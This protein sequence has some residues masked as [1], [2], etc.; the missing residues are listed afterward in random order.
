M[1]TSGDDMNHVLEKV[2]A[3]HKLKREL[4]ELTHRDIFTVCVAEF[5]L[6]NPGL[7]PLILHQK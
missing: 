1:A 2:Y 7:S 5:G 4:E 6:M 3:L